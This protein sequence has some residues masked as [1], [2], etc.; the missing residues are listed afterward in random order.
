R[1][2]DEGAPSPL[3]TRGPSVFGFH[4][5]EV[6]AT[7]YPRPRARRRG[8]L[9]RR[10]TTSRSVTENS[11][12]EHRR[13]C[14]REG[15]A[16]FALP[17]V[18]LAH[19]RAQRLRFCPWKP[20]LATR[21]RGHDEVA[22]SPLRTRGPSVLGFHAHEVKAT[23]YPRPRARRKV[24]VYAVRPRNGWRPLHPP[25]EQHH[26]RVALA[27]A[28]VQ[29]LLLSR[30][31]P[32][33]TRGPSVFGSPARRPCAREGPVSSVLPVETATG[34]PRPRARRRSTVALANA[35]AQCPLLSRPSPLRTRG[36]SV[37]GFDRGNRHW[38]PA[39]AGTTK[40]HRR[41]CAREGPVSSVLPADT[42]K[43]RLLPLA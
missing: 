12:K 26:N 23:G 5:H 21:V 8:D 6:K 39:S 3:R 40:E 7:G 41:P 37:F 35:R 30:P 2:H 33:R 16:S 36:P 29:R 1:G 13:P 38:V 43:T 10:I 28:R 24:V 34:Y 25:S 42:D 32:L 11:T 27:H 4:A 20:P 9:G 22:P 18:A 17:L 19:A 15:P 14:A 31:S